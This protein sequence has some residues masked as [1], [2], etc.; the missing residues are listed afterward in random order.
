[1]TQ[2]QRTRWTHCCQGFLDSFWMVRVLCSAS[3]VGMTTM[4]Q[5]ARPAV[6]ASCS[7]SFMCSAIREIRL[8]RKGG[9]AS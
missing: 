3:Q 8:G 4:K 7:S 2:T 5:R 1:M 9:L 6:S